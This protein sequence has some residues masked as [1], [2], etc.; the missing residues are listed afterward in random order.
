MAVA[1]SLGLFLTGIDYGL[2][3]LGKSLGQ[4]TLPFLGASSNFG[5]VIAAFL[6]NIGLAS[7]FYHWLRLPNRWWIVI[8]A[9]LTLSIAPDITTA[10]GLPHLLEP[11]IIGGLYALVYGF[12]DVLYNGL[13]IEPTYKLVISVVVIWF[14]A[15]GLVDLSDAAT[16]KQAARQQETA[17]QKVGFTLYAPTSNTGQ[18]V[19]QDYSFNS[20]SEP[21]YVNL[22]FSHNLELNVFKTPAYFNPPTNCGQTM[23]LSSTLADDNVDYNCPLVAT[24]QR[25]RPVYAYTQEANIIP[26]QPVIPESYFTEI[27][28]V[29]V[30]IADFDPSTPLSAIETLIDTLNPV[31]VD[32]LNSLSKSGSSQ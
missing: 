29:V 2:M 18:F 4:D 5:E 19:F 28:G 30:S 25:G 24:T 6:V 32:Q 15:A 20:Y 23:P 8:L 31:T 12:Y 3:Q 26:G 17:L 9:A 14:V 27:D 16:T 10:L 1:F 7:V 21:A 11:F 22:E 13:R